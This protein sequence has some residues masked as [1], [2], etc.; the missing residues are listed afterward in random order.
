[1]LTRVP[2]VYMYKMARIAGVP[3]KLEFA[4]DTAK[5][6]FL[7]EPKTITTL[8]NYLALATKKVGPLTAIMREQAQFQMQWRLARRV[9]SNAP[10][11]AT[12]SFGRASTFDQ[13]DLHSANLDFEKEIAAYE[14]WF[15]EKGKG[16]APK[17][18]APGF[19]NDYEKEW[20]EIAVWW[21]KAPPL[22][23]AVLS[24]FDEYVHDSRAWFKLIPGKPDSEEDMH[25]LLR[26]WAMIRQRTRERQVVA[27]KLLMEQQRDLLRR[28]G[29][30]QD[31]NTPKPPPS[32]D[33]LTVAQ[34]K[35]ADEY[36]RTKKIPSMLTEGREPFEWLGV[37][38][39][40][41]YL[42]YRKVYGGR[43]SVLISDTGTVIND[44]REIT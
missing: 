42:R 28:T 12:A 24:F 25:A 11:E 44:D 31:E 10:L 3:L 27:D 6:R 5:K 32:P 30:K 29:R 13:N 34:R 41:G 19:G 8:N 17:P 36:V 16:F 38:G 22:P 35:A 26:E 7:I 15:G 1:M 39:R 4:S 20:E 2:L 40:A 21:T 33:G 18:Q 23:A 14:A 43:D 37:S 9:K